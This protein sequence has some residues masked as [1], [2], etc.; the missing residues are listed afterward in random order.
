M[1]VVAV[2]RDLAAKHSLAKIQLLELS[3]HHAIAAAHVDGH[4]DILVVNGPLVYFR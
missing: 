2:G 4:K 1:P 3:N